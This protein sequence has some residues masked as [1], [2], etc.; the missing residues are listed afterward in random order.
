MTRREFLYASLAVNVA[1]QHR[2]R[3]A[4]IHLTIDSLS[5]EVAPGFVYKTTAYNGMAPARVLRLRQGLP[6]TVEISN[7]TS[8]DEYVH[9]HGLD[10]PPSIDGT[11]EEASMVVPANG[12]IRYSFTPHQAGARWIH[13]HAMAH[14]HLDRGVYS[15]QYGIVYVEPKENLGSYDREFFLAAH[16]WGAELRWVQQS[17]EEQE[18]EEDENSAGTLPASG[19]WEVQYDVGSINGK[20]LGAGEPLQVKEGDRVL[21]HILNASATATQRFALPGHRFK[22]LALDGNI[23]PNPQYVEILELGA[24]ERVSAVVEMTN[25]GVWILGAV[26]GSDRVDGRMGIVVEY[27]GRSN[28]PRWIDPSF[29]PWDYAIFAGQR[30]QLELPPEQLIPMVIDRGAT[31]RDGMESWT[32]NGNPYDGVPKR[33]RCG[34]RYR[35]IFDNRSDEDHPVHFHRYSFELTR[36]HGRSISGIWKDVVMLKRYARMELDFIPISRGLALFHCHQQMH[37]DAGFKKLFEVV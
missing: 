17:E 15:G 7:R 1:A 14:G 23:V 8:L 35:F 5:H 13:S 32:I 30:P 21:F 2:S 36:L 9:W 18:D 29:Q 27:A 28:A 3:P 25:P 19:G 6:V 10:V 37:M 33:L 34:L 16:E 26:R 24:G 11:E 4:D 12:H 22:V 20:A 31:G